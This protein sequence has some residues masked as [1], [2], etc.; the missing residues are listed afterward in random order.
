MAPAAVRG[1]DW[2]LQEEGAIESRPC[3]HRRK[4]TALGSAE[5]SPGSNLLPRLIKEVNYLEI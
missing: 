1:G 3:S 5:A 4:I 2:F